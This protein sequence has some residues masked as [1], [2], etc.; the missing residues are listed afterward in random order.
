MTRSS[1]VS[2][3]QPKLSLWRP[4]SFTRPT[5]AQVI[6]LTG[7]GNTASIGSLTPDLASA[8]SAAISER[9]EATGSCAVSKFPVSS[10]MGHIFFLDRFRRSP[11]STPLLG[12]ACSRKE[13]TLVLH[14]HFD[15]PR[16]LVPNRA[17]VI[18]SRRTLAFAADTV[19]PSASAISNGGVLS[20]TR[21]RSRSSSSRVHRSLL[22]AATHPFAFSP[23]STSRRMASER[24]A[25]FAQ[26]RLRPR[27][28]AR[29]ACE[30]SRADPVPSRDASRLFRCHLN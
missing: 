10:A 27:Q 30:Q 21:S 4:G 7:D 19:R 14:L 13:C 1:A 23:K 20:N 26:P 17:R 18:P 24:E 6:L 2:I 22:F 12:E 25:P 28:S 29:S 16:R 5:W 8:S 9:D 15:K 11:P 3:S